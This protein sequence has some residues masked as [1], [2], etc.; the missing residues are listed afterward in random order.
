MRIKLQ[1][2]WVYY[3]SIS[4]FTLLA[5]FGLLYTYHQFQDGK[6]LFIFSKTMTLILTAILLK[7]FYRIDEFPFY[8]NLGIKP[9][10]LILTVLGFDLTLFVILLNLTDLL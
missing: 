6:S 3:K 5:S 4:P 7:F 10:H 1:A 8:E 9:N 2:I